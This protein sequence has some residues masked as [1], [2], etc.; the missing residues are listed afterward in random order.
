MKEVPGVKSYGIPDD[1]EE[2]EENFPKIR[3][4]GDLV[5]K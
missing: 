3:K 5:E 4:K 1:T 2:G